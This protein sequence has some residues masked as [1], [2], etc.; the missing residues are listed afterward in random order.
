MEIANLPIGFRFNPTDAELLYYLKKKVL[1]LPLPANV[2]PELEA[3]QFNPWDLPGGLNEKRFF[4]CKRK[5]NLMSKC[6]SCGYWK[7]SGKE[8]QIVAG[9][10]NHV[11][12]MMKTFVFYQGRNMK[13]QWIMQEFTIA[14]HLKT[15]FL[16]QRLMMKVGNWVVC[17]LYQRVMRA[18]NHGAAELGHS[19][20]Q[21][22]PF[23][24]MSPW[25]SS[26]ITDISSSDLD[27]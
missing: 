13:T 6:S 27:E 11:I 8:K 25:S 2:I 24:P 5:K 16:D 10:S 9:E 14:G 17:R 22:T 18:R 20:A 26:E 1:S 19:I 7:S 12:G 4:F 21:T 23:I 3:F 15:P